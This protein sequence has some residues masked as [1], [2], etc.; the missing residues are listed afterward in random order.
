MRFRV[1]RS[2]D[3]GAALVIALVFITV[4]AI[5]V[6]VTLSFA[7]TSIR[8]TFALRD[9]A[10]YSANADGAAQIAVNALRE[11]TYNGTSGTCFGGG[12]VLTLSNVYQPAGGPADSAYVAC[13]LDNDH[14]AT[15]PSV[16]INASNRPGSA[17]L[18]MSTGGEDGINIKVSGG[19]TVKVHGGIFSNSNINVELGALETNAEVTARGPCAG[20]IT[21]TPARQCN[22]GG[23]PNPKGEDPNYAPAAG[24]ATPRAVPTCPGNGN[25]PRLITFDPGR[26]T[27]LSALNSLTSS[28]DN[29][30]NANKCKGSIFHFRPGTYYFDFGGEWLVD[31][32]YLVGGTETSTLDPD[33]PPAIPGA[34]Q[35][36]I[37]PNPLPPGGW[38]KPAP[39]AGVQFI[40]GGTSRIHLGAAR[41]EICGTYSL[42][43]PP[44][45]V[46]GLKSAHNGVPAQSGCVTTV[47]GC[48]VILS[49]NAPTS[50]LYVQGTTYVPRAKLDIS[51]NNLTG[52][53]FRYGV[54]ARSLYLN[55]TGSASLSNPV[56][57]VPDE[58]PSYGRRTVIN[59]T[60]YVCPGSSTCSTSGQLRLRVKVG[61]IDPTGTAV[62]GQREITVY[63]WSVQR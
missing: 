47:G 63:N 39:D 52:Q 32:G 53:V 11:G 49:D 2:D 1:W 34:C 51:L 50:R 43:S 30:P 12:N 3:G 37:P 57:E 31:T 60:V 5:A 61:V 62:A 19:R 48:A 44:V 13:T 23:A 24:P 55:P 35:S 17:I 15:D 41:F 10:A 46:Y 16:A 8:T 40:F 42:T 29:G 26:Y 54:V 20:S 58:S 59:L 25:R 38:T 9:Q 21:S 36:P 6:T 56:I 22:I 14:T 27:N 45:A 4:V 33:N 7:D 18:T 28:I